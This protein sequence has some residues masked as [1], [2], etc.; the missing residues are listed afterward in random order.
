MKDEKP[1][2]YPG[3]KTSGNTRY[4]IPSSL[5]CLISWMTF[6]MVACLFMNTGAACTAATVSL[7]DIL[8][9]GR[10]SILRRLLDLISLV[11]CGLIIVN[12]WDILK[13]RE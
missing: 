7:L 13:F 9:I 6:C 3:T 5:A 8:L 1:T 10:Y 4:S 12:I 11:E 2:G